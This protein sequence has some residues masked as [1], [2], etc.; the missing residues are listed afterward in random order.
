MKLLFL[1]VACAFVVP[2]AACTRN[3]QNSAA[4]IQSPTIQASPSPKTTPVSVTK[5]WYNYTAKDGSYTA[6][7]PKQPK[8]EDKLE[9][10]KIGKHT[11][12]RAMYADKAKNRAYM[13]QSTKYPID[14]SQYNAEKGLDGARDSQA[15]VG[16]TV[17][18]EKKITLNGFPGRELIMQNKDG[19]AMKMRM[20]IDPN[21]P[22]LF[23][24]LVVAGNGNLD[25]P[26]VQP[27]LDSLAV[28]K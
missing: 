9:D 18:S 24:A 14:P 25:F 11:S 1:S 5:N 10:S 16:N 15:K 17:T 27:F 12:F 4:A 26:E 13:T 7:F 19:M 20:F 8:E 3:S 2:L 23:M 28:P 22:T 21:G 6:K